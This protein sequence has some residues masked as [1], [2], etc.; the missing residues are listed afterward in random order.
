MDVAEPQPETK[1]QPIADESEPGGAVARRLRRAA[2]SERSLTVDEWVSA[3][4]PEVQ[5]ER[6]KGGAGKAESVLQ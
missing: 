3:G 1:L 6:E 5:L 4:Q 2:F